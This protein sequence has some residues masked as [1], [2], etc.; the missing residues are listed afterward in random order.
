MPWYFSAI[1]SAA[2][3]VTGVSDVSAT[4]SPKASSVR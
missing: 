2:A 3:A 4:V 1:C